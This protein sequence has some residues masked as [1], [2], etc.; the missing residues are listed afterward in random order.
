M[1]NTDVPN[2]K[3]A[4]VS[5]LALS[6]H[7]SHQ[8]KYNIPQKSGQGSK[9]SQ[10]RSVLN[11]SSAATATTA[12]KK[13]CRRRIRQQVT[14]TTTAL[15]VGRVVVKS[16]WLSE[17]RTALVNR[18]CES[19]G[20]TQAYTTLVDRADP[21][22]YDFVQTVTTKIWRKGLPPGLKPNETR[23][24]KRT[25]VIPSPTATAVPQPLDRPVY[26]KTKLQKINK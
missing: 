21:K 12:A 11:T 1:S 19:R 25:H 4:V 14:H 2:K 26:Q 13:P 16:R 10:H 9:S 20:F 22:K 7:Q 24:G 6:S 15:T 8:N 3:P 18:R 5:R 23:T 17:R